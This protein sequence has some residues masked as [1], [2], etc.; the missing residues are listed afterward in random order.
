MSTGQV[1]PM[2]FRDPDEPADN[3]PDIDPGANAEARPAD[4]D[5][6][7]I[8]S[9]RPDPDEIPDEEDPNDQLPRN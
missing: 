3:D 6:P 8:E 2:P 5:E 9:G 7:L 4:R 1:N